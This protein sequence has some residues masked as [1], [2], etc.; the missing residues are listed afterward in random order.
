MYSS[1]SSR[2]DDLVPLIP[3]GTDTDDGVAEDEG[4]AEVEGTLGSPSGGVSKTLSAG[5]GSSSAS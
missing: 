5:G 3:L 2:Y 4:G 1:Q